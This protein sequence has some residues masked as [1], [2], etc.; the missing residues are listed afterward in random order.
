MHE[1]LR[2]NYEARIPILES[3]CEALESETFRAIQDVNH[4]DR[5]YFRVKDT[6]S[7]VKKAL[8]PDNDPPYKD[9]LAE[10][11]DQVAGRIIVFFREDLDL[12]MDRLRGTF[13][14]IEF[15]R[16]RPAADAEFG[17]ETNHVICVVPPQ[18]KTSDSEERNDLPETFELQIRTIFMH[19]YAEPQHNFGY[20]SVKDLPSDIRRELAW[21]GASAWGA[22]QAYQ[23]VFDWR[24]A[25][26]DN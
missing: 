14:S 23:R 21:I 19:A 18:V 22:D 9:P 16:R 24:K 4:I 8:D 6:V 7:F 15:E 17:Y 2:Q 11:E 26:E 25:N 12:I 13:N 20:K 5:V 10:I 1:K 3:L